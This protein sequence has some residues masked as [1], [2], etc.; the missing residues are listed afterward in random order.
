MAILSPNGP[1][2]YLIVNADDFGYSARVNAAV[3]RAHREGILTS[4]S[5]M[6][7]EEG[8]Q[9]AVAIAR[10]TPTLG[11]GLHVVTTFDRATLP[12]R[13]IPHLVDSMGKFP[14]DPLR[15]GL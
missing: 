7:A 11:V 1:R 2:R 9:E 10:Q 13:D 6:V 14:K 12:A 4:A 3:L 8:W 15:A 5:L